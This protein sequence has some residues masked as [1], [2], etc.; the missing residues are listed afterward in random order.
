MPCN[1]QNLQENIFENDAPVYTCKFSPLQ[2]DYSILAVANENGF[3]CLD[4][5]K[6]KN[7]RT[8]VQ[9][10]NNTVF[11]LAWMPGERQFVTVSG[12]H[13]AKLWDCSESEVKMV[14]EFLGHTRS[15]KCVHFKLE[16]TG[17]TSVI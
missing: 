6:R 1:T 2:N 15:V 5:T 10:H 9:T 3:V 14:S 13:S 11:D 17:K 8:F 16:N 12:D 4:D 7:A